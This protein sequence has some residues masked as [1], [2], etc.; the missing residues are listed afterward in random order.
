MTTVR[1]LITQSLKDLGAIAVGETPTADEAQDAFEALKQMCSTWQTEALVTYAKN[2]QVFTFPIAGQRS[3]TIGPTGDLVSTRPVRIDA[4]YNRDSNNNDYE[5]YVAK[6]F[7]DYSQLITKAVSAQIQTIVYYD[8]TFPNGTL[9][10]WPTPSDLSY[11]LVL[12]T[13]TSVTEFATLDDV[14]ALPPGYERALRSNLAVELSP[15]YG[16][17]V[18]D[19]LAKTANE[20][21]AQIKRTNMTIPTMRFELGIGQRGSNFNYLTGQPT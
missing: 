20:S 14:I 12:W 1:T 13:W 9:Y 5:L 18:M 17:D 6:D 19:A 2:Q 16:R 15:R 7:T 4:A 10:M 8:P 21:K 3:Y 11:R